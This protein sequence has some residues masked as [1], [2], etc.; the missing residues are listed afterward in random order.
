MSLDCRKDFPSLELEINGRRGVHL[1]GP[2]GTQV[3][4]AVI[5][6]IS[7]Y[8]RSSNANLHGFFPTSKRT[9]LVIKAVREDLASFLGAEGPET[10]SIGQNMTTLTFSLSH[11]IGRRLRKGDEVIITALDHE[12][13]RGPWL[14][15]KQYGLRIREVA[16]TGQGELDYE[17]LRKKIN[18]RTR[19]IA[20]G[21]AS[22]AFGTV[23][24]VKDIVEMAR[25][26][27]AMV[28]VDAV[29]YAPHFSVNVQE[30]GCDFLLCSSYK[31][32][33]PHLG[34]LYTYPGTLDRLDP[35]RLRTQVQKAP[36]VIETGTL[37][38]ASLAGAS[39]AVNYIA[40]YGAGENLAQSLVDAKRKIQA[41][42]RALA[43]KLHA[44]LDEIEGLEIIGL[45][46]G[47]SLRAPTLSFV[48]EGLSPQII[49][50]SLGEKGICSWDGH[51]Y[52]IRAIEVLGLYERGGVTRLGIS[53]YNNEEEIE[54]TIGVL[55]EV[56][57]RATGSKLTLAS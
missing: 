47:D 31:F 28:V 9:D 21:W 30:L 34:F 44:G 10:I 45:P 16:L 53:M 52:A 38:H 37:N 57:K 4:Q 12:A 22:N 32:Y 33:G 29:H 14:G 7:G 40:G 6:A 43:E 25:T 5:D 39:A 26:V 56:A 51:F 41:H 23:N 48:I 42:E 18:S 15:L 24:R 55:E 20:V 13:N 35:D 8:Y 54:Y 17:D 27:D 36:F 2:G 1:D 46:F 19:L 3:P 11:A 49:S 50:K